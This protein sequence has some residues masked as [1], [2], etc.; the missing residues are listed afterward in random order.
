MLAYLIDDLICPACHASLKW[1]IHERDG[2]HIEQGLATCDECQADY[3]VRDGIAIFLLPNL[4][5]NDLWEQVEN[6]LAQFLL[7]NPEKEKQLID[8][9]LESLDPADKFFRAMMLEEQGEFEGARSLYQIA[10]ASLYTPEYQICHESQIHFL[11]EHLADSTAPIVDLASGRGELVEP[12]LHNLGCPVT[13]TDFSLR[14]LR[15]NRRWFAY[16]GLDERLSLM[17]FDARCTP[18]RECSLPCLTTNL[19]L[20]NIEQPG[21][22]L[23]ELRRIVSGE[24][25]AISY[26]I[27]PEDIESFAFIKENEL[28]PMFS[29]TELKKHLLAAGWHVQF[30][31]PCHALAKPTPTSRILEGAGIDAIPT[32]PTTLQWSLV[33][34]I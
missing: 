1:Q 2:E 13:A 26:F 16:F 28:S 25:L 12:L 11:L 3:P 18:F 20:P 24:L 17:A 19:G 10:N 5:R 6:S 32:A 14:V 15:R 29:R 7:D 4:P 9:P 27:D 22:L 33:T 21:K 8:S 23:S 34:A 30:A 31:N